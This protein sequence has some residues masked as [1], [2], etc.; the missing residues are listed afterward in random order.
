MDKHVTFLL[1]PITK[2][3]V[4]SS[5]L[6]ESSTQNQTNLKKKKRRNSLKE[7]IGH[8]YFKATEIIAEVPK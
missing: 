6:G 1:G 4:L 7:C 2:A 5:D 3:C 8:Y